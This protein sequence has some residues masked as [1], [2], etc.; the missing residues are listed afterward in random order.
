VPLKAPLKIRRTGPAEADSG[1]YPANG[2]K[3]KGQLPAGQVGYC[4]S[5]AEHTDITRTHGRA[6]YGTAQRC[7]NEINRRL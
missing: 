6:D 5:A 2:R 7:E 4:L 3:R 1:P